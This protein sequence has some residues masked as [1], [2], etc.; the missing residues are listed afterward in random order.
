[1]KGCIFKRMKLLAGSSKIL[2]DM[3]IWM[4]LIIMGNLNNISNIL[5]HKHMD[6]SLRVEN[7]EVKADYLE[8]YSMLKLQT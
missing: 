6:K 3:K 7:Q 4:I 2:E 5:N 8:E 1:M